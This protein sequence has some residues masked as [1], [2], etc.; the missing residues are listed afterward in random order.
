VPL[1]AKTTVFDPMIG[2]P[3]CSKCALIQDEQ[4]CWTFVL[5]GYFYFIQ[6]FMPLC[7]TYM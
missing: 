5:Y 2:A 7:K 1:T 3:R 4:L 6:T